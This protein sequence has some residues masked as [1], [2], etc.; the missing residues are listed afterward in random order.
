MFKTGGYAARLFDSGE[1]CAFFVVFN[2]QQRKV[3]I[4]HCEPHGAKQ[5]PLALQPMDVL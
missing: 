1:A 2:W 4:C 3:V 5:S